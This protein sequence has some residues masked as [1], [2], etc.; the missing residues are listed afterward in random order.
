M[1]LILDAE[2]PERVIWPAQVEWCGLA[3]TRTFSC[4]RKISLAK[5]TPGWMASTS[6]KTTATLLNELHTADNHPT[7]WEA[8]D[9][10]P[11][12]TAV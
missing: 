6:M 12:T 8:D 7:T 5:S 9:W 3:W 11:L 1:E 2:M 4:Q 10:P